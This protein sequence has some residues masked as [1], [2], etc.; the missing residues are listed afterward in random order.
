MRKFIL[1]INSLLLLTLV[2]CATAA[3]K[4][5]SAGQIGCPQEEVEIT[6]EN[7]GFST[8]SWVATCRG[9]RFYC[10]AVSGGQYGGATVACKE[11]L[12]RK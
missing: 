4:E 10:S 11:E 5:A 9:Q 1:M 7:T 6:D 2:G 3:R 8:A 12:K